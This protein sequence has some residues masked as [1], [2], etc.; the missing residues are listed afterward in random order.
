MIIYGE[1]I[2]DPLA[3]LQ[4]DVLN[5]LLGDPALGFTNVYK[6]KDQKP[7]DVAM[8]NISPW[9][10]RSG[11]EKQGTALEVRMPA[12]RAKYPNLPGPQQ[13]LELTL[14]CMEDPVQN[15]SGLTC[16]A[17]AW[18]AQAW[19]DGQSIEA[20]GVS[21]LQLYPDPRQPG[22]RPVYGEYTDR[23]AYDVVLIA[24]WPQNARYRVA[25]P[26]LGDDDAGNVTLT[27]VDN[28]API[29][30]TVDGT[31]PVVPLPGTNVAGAT[32]VYAGPFAV[33][34]GTLVRWLAWR[35]GFMQSFVGNA[36]V[37]ID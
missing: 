28:A 34:N 24:D 14:R 2:L 18:E 33:G 32:K 31:M 6:F 30:Y 1:T 25:Q 35:S 16:E 11:Q 12:I 3:M 23:F 8:Q 20:T 19:L 36:L 21:G 10:D 7:E 37:T 9:V 15:L 29:Y 26:G 4:S 22:V 17:V 13:E 27:A 5:L